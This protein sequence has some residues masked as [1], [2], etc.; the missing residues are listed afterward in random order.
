MTKTYVTESEIEIER[1]PEELAFWVRNKL[2][3]IAKLPGGMKAVRFRTGLCKE[4]VE[5]VFPLSTWASERFRGEVA[6]RLLP[7]IG[8]QTY[9][10]IVKDYTTIPP[11]ISH[12]EITAAREG[13]AEHLRMLMLYDQGWAWGM[14]RL[15]KTG[16]KRTGIQIKVQ[17]ALTSRLEIVTRTHNLVRKAVLKKLGKPYPAG[18]ELVVMFEDSI[19]VRETIGEILQ[20][21]CDTEVANMNLP[22]ERVWLVGSFGG[23]YASCFVSDSAL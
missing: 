20:D 2:D 23:I 21:Y 19:P 22:F 13:E 7:I 5:E 11:R 6:I 3:E 8:N 15:E 10:A 14:A 9:D 1:S 18:T 12:V 17:R 16:T 4:F